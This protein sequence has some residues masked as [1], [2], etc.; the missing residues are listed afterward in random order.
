MLTIN[1][2]TIT[3][4]PDL[5]TDLAHESVLRAHMSGYVIDRTPSGWVG[6][7]NERP[8]LAIMLVVV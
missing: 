4:N 6:T 3:R 8:D 2:T 5:A 1:G 7:H